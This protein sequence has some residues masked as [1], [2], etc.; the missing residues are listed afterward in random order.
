MIRR[1]LCG[2]TLLA[3][4]SCHSDINS[5]S[6]K[7]VPMGAITY[8]TYLKPTDAEEWTADFLQ[9][10]DREKLVDAIF[11]AVYS[12]QLTAYD[13]FSLEPIAVKTIQEMEA[14]GEFVRERIGKFQFNETWSWN[15]SSHRL[16]KKVS[17]LTIGY[18]VFNNQGELRGHKPIFKINFD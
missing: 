9:E 10:L 3:L 16:E 14:T 1:Q 11:E 7:M 17:G 18:E 5:T 2:L 6:G 4:L 13:Y 15:E 8:D 12:G